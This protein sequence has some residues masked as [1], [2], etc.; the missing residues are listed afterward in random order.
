MRGLLLALFC[1]LSIS[2]YAYEEAPIDLS[3]ITSLDYGPELFSVGPNAVCTKW[4]PQRQCITPGTCQF[5]WGSTVALMTTAAQKAGYLYWGA[6]IG[7]Q[8]ATYGADFCKKPNCFTG[9]RC[10][11]WIVI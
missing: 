7:Q 9:S 2:A 3:S 6:F 4:E 8:V 11:R 10:L 1:L 5:F